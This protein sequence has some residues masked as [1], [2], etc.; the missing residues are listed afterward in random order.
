MCAIQIADAVKGNLSPKKNYSK[1]DEYLAQ[2][3]NYIEVVIEK[4]AYGLIKLSVLFFYRRIFWVNRR[5]RILTNVLIGLV[6]TWAVAFFWAEI[7]VCG[8]R[9]SLMWKDRPMAALR[10]DNHGL[11]L[12]VFAATDVVGDLIIVSM[13]FFVIWKLQ[14]VRREKLAVSGV[15]LLAYL[16]TAAGIMRLGFIVTAYH[17]G[18]MGFIS[19][20]APDPA[21]A[22]LTIVNPQ[23]W[24]NFEVVIG[25]IAA[26]LP[27]LG[28]LIRSTPTPSRIAHTIRRKMSL[29][30]HHSTQA[31]LVDPAELEK[32]KSPQSSDVKSFSDASS[33]RYTLN[34]DQNGVPS[35]P[36]TALDVGGQ[37]RASEMLESAEAYVQT[38][39]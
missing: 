10:C 8:T 4:P 32:G 20:P 27:P 15:F 5:F 6:T 17:Y 11:E 24:T 13:P 35:I 26:C 3:W 39:H 14:M 21:P 1:Q 19:P 2:K 23:F 31:P 33:A 7:F 28:P 29:S 16:S 30:S 37:I 34:F 36:E 18:L 9:F 25:C 22:V 38:R 12:L